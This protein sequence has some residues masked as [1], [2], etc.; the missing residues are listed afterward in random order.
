MR[1]T[2]GEAR[3]RRI[4]G[5]GRL[6]I[7]PTSDRVREALFDIVGKRIAGARFLDAC[8]GTGAVGI[9]ALSRGARQVVFVERDP[10]AVRRIRE[11][12]E[13]GP[14]EGRQRIEGSDLKRAVAT[15]RERGDLFQIIYLDPPYEHPAPAGVIAGVAALLAPRGVLV[16][17]HRAARAP[18]LSG[19]HGLRP[20]RTYRYGDTAL[21]LLHEGDGGDV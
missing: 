15:M 1:L 16:I 21:T 7:R 11:N 5:P 2:G 20:G 18:E 19:A 3:G 14:W 13:R 12:L 17:E 4:K 6:P 10:R 8:A 9:E